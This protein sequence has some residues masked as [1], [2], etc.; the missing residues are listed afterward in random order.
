MIPSTV[1][2]VIS[3]LHEM[4]GACSTLQNAT[5]VAIWSAFLLLPDRG[6]LCPVRWYLGISDMA[7]LLSALFVGAPPVGGCETACCIFC[8]ALAIRARRGR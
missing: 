7:P 1:R 8:G 5:S 2:T 6:A 3:L 4:F